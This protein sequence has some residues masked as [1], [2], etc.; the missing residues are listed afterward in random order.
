MCI[1]EMHRGYFH[2]I[3]SMFLIGP[4][5][6]PLATTIHDQASVHSRA[7]DA[8]PTFRHAGTVGP[9]HA[10]LFCVHPVRSR[11]APRGA[12]AHVRRMKM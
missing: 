11:T 3:T 6:A 1:G 2:T 10:A 12:R 4:E 7:S 5:I 9:V 8:E